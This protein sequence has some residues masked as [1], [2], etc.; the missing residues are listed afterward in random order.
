M[1]EGTAY[2]NVCSDLKCAKPE[3]NGS[4]RVDLI[5]HLKPFRFQSCLEMLKQST[6]C[7]I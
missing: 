3:A 4:T 1:A 7:D 2:R 6:N 5:S